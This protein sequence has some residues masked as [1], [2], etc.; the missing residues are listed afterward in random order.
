MDTN[1]PTNIGAMKAAKADHYA[2]L[3]D[4][5]MGDVMQENLRMERCVQRAIESINHSLT[6]IQSYE[7]ALQALSDAREILALAVYKPSA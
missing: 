1:S 5:S 7:Q 6:S 2:S 4:P 3:R